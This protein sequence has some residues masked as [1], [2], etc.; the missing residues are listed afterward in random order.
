MRLL[1]DTSVIIPLEDSSAILEESLAQVSRLVMEHGHLLLVHPSSLDDI[2]RDMDEKRRL[3]SLS[4]IQKYPLLS[5]PPIPTK[6]DLENLN[7][8]QRND[9]D[10]VDN[11]LLYAIYRDAAN[12]LITEDRRLHKKAERIGLA[13][14]VHYVQQAANFLSR[15]Y[16]S[17]E[18]IALPNIQEIFLHNLDLNTEFFDSLRN[19][20]SGFDDWFREAAREGRSAWAVYDEGGNLGAIAIYKEEQDP[21]VTNDHRA[22]PGKVLKL[23]TFKVGETIRG[24]KIG[25]LLLKCAF[26]YA[27]RNKFEHI[28]L[29]MQVGKQDFL[30]DLC[31]DFGFIYFGEYNEDQVFVKSQPGV[32]PS[33]LFSALEYHKR[34]YPHFRCDEQIQKFIVPIRPEFHRILFPDIQNQLTQPTLFGPGNIQD[35]SPPAAAGNAIKQAY[36]CHAR[37]KNINPGDILIFYRSRD[38]MALTTVGIVE[39]VYDIADPDKILELV[40]KRTVYTFEEIQKMAERRTKVILFRTAVHLPK[41][42]KSEW[43]SEELGILSPIQSI[44]Q[45][46]DEAFRRLI[47]ESEISNCFYAD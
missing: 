31:T 16:A 9:H 38:E 17:R 42:I 15:I 28:Y 21:R 33:D 32:P 12:I 26:R 23:S 3:I 43:L 20:Y 41:L 29:T 34:F 4:R 47:G 30:K 40:S 18:E 35:G 19:D 24:R 46:T 10:R 7:L 1:L 39:S 2:N 27:S 5:G 22:L 14:R 44:R 25:E 8:D 11:E 6:D 13:D 37:I 36:L 45:I